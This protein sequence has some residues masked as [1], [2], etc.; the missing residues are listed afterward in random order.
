[1]F[2]LQSWTVLV[3]KVY[4]HISLCGIYHSDKQSLFFSQKYKYWHCKV[5]GF[6]K[7]VISLPQIASGQSGLCNVLSSFSLSIFSSSLVHSFAYLYFTAPPVFCVDMRHA[8]VARNGVSRTP[9]FA[10]HLHLPFIWL[11]GFGQVPRRWL[12]HRTLK[13]M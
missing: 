4:F 3:L 2:F 11:G 12:T 5:V 1:M 10:L 9:A 8:L 6:K 7:A 13:N